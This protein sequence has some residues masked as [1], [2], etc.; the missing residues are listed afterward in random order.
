[1]RIR[2]NIELFVRHKYS[3][4]SYVRRQQDSP[5]SDRMLIILQLFPLF[6]HSLK[7]LTHSVL[8]H[9]TCECAKFV[10]RSVFG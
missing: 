8:I 3:T 2:Q 6:F 4:I 9:M 1:M 10:Q 5:Q 7:E